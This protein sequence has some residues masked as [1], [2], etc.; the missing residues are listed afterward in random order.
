MLEITLSIFQNSIFEKLSTESIFKKKIH[1]FLIYPK[2][3][4]KQGNCNL[5]KIDLKKIFAKKLIIVWDVLPNDENFE[6]QKK[7]FEQFSS[8]FSKVRFQDP[9]I[10]LFLE[11]NYPEI[12]LELSLEKFS[13]NI[14]SILEWQKFFQKRLQKIIFSNL[15]PLSTIKKWR[16]QIFSKVEIL[17]FGKLEIFYSPR[18]L[19]EEESQKEVF[20]E[21][22]DRLG[23]WNK[24]VQNSSGSILYNSKDICLLD[25]LQ[26]IQEAKIDAI[27]IEPNNLTQ[28][29]LIQQ[30]L[31]SKQGLKSLTTLWKAEY[32]AGF[33]RANKTNK[34]FSMLKNKHLYPRQKDL[35]KI[36]KVIES[37]KG[38][39]S[40]I[41]LT[42]TV[43]LPCLIFI[44]SPEKKILELE[45]KTLQDLQK[46]AVL[47][48]KNAYYL[49]DYIPQAVA[50][51]L[52][53]KSI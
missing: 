12:D 47:K 17:G 25:Y 18:A 2:I 10:G 33:F 14:Y 31:V 3:L 34:Q 46:K 41:N 9:G 22:I 52:I 13:H 36:G 51:S 49:T 45:L 32:L 37:K 27:R 53:Y 16:P 19:L 23:A 38:S 5:Y 39:Y 1:Q 21:S 40:L 26:E 50:N 43:I 15:T 30:A 28:L 20:I 44:Y 7:I 35:K 4:S 48:T 42:E 11:K 24:L 8:F 6:L 29:D